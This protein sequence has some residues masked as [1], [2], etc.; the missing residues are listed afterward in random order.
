MQ[1]TKTDHSKHPLNRSFLL[2]FTMAATIGLS[3]CVSDS[4]GSPRSSSDDTSEATRNNPNRGPGNNSGGGGGNPHNQPSDESPS[5][6]S[7]TSEEIAAPEETEEADPAV[8]TLT[9]SWTAPATRE[10]GDAIAL[11]QI[12]RYALYIG[13]SSGSY[14]DPIEIADTGSNSYALDFLDAGTYYVAMKV[15]DTDGLWSRHSEE[16]QIVIQ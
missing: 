14:G 4:G 10:N 8:E 16:V 9:L 1:T 3:A 6:D 15:A 5:T 12:D 2:A 11:S 13:T 7:G